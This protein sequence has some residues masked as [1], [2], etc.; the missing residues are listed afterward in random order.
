ML[1]KRSLGQHFLVDRRAVR[2]IVSA[3]APRRGEF[4]LEIGPGR[5]A[6]TDDL[7]AAVGQLAV[8]EL[9]R[10]L[11]AMLRE[12]FPPESLVIFERDV[13]DIDVAE[14]LGAMG[15][16][17]GARLV[18]AGNL[19]Y[20]VSKP[21]AAKLIRDRARISRAVLTF[22]REV[23]GRL[24]ARPGGKEYGPLSVLA[25]LTYRVGA[26]FDLPPG[27][28]RPP[29]RVV[30]TVTAWR[31][32]EAGDALSAEQEPRLRAV[33]AACFARRRRTLRGNLRTALGDDERVT[34]L[35]EAAAL[36]GGRRAETLEPEQFVRLA[37]LWN[38]AALL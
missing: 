34:R 37:E 20:Y 3:L 17:A 36:D 13:L 21:I 25:A 29:P 35:L 19:P 16:P 1:A 32:R 24:T 4:V 26:L 30:S 38:V 5:G 28:F 2:R 11:A 7:V 14:V 9:D 31:P 15:A 8:V 33:L 23:A 10:G 27:A 22:Q 18:I 12:R 6:L